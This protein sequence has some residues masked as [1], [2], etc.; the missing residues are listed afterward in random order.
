MGVCQG[1]PSL[2]EKKK[3]SPLIALSWSLLPALPFLQLPWSCSLPTCHHVMNLSNSPK[4]KSVFKKINFQNHWLNTA[5]INV[6]INLQPDHHLMQLLLLSNQLVL[7]HLCLLQ[8]LL[9]FPAVRNSRN[10]WNCT[11]GLVTFPCDKNFHALVCL[12]HW[13]SRNNWR[14]LFVPCSTCLPCL[15]FKD[16]GGNL[17]VPWA[18]ES[19]VCL[20]SISCCMDRNLSSYSAFTD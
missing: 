7:R 1:H 13:G 19:S 2:E 15:T 5:L 8:L 9:K 18:V 17:I 4:L 14:N 11:G 12:W 3:E 16:F 10:Y 20:R 6:G